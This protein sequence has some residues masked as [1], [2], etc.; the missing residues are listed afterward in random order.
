MIILLYIEKPQTLRL[1]IGATTYTHF[2]L[3]YQTVDIKV[4]YLVNNQEILF[5]TF[6]G[7]LSSS[8]LTF[9]TKNLF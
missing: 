3:Q 8:S 7:N 5:G 2:A 1:T 9:P 6:I 4:I